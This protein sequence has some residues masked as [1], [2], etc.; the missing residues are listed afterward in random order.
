MLADFKIKPNGDVIV[1]IGNEQ[2]EVP[3]KTLAA[4]AESGAAAQASFAIK[5]RAQL[6][7]QLSEAHTSH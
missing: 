6:L 2:A 1:C 5:L 4:V 7:N 3:L